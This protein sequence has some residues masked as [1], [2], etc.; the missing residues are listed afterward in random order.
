MMPGRLLEPW[1]ELQMD[2]L[3]IDTPSLTGHN[4][5]LLVVDRASKFPF[6]FPLETRQA[7]GV[8]RVLVEL[9]LTSGVP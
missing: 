6:G 1:D 7:V 8:A 3:K 9:C 4:Y 5:I 2:I